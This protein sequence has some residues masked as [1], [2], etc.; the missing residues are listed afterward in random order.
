[1]LQDR[2]N[3]RKLR[4]ALEQHTNTASVKSE[5]HRKASLFFRI[6]P[7]DDERLFEKFVR[8]IRS[9]NNLSEARRMR[10]EISSQL[11]KDQRD[12]S[13]DPT[14]LKRLEAGKHLLDQQVSLL[15]SNTVDLKRNISL[16]DNGGRLNLKKK[17]G[18]L[19][20]IRDVTEIL[21]D[22]AG[23]SYFMEYMDRQHRLPL[24]QF[25]LVVDG[26]RN[27]LEDDEA[28]IVKWSSSDRNDLA[29]IYDVY[30]NA[31]ELKIAE[32]TKA[33]VREFL[34]AGSKASTVGYKRARAAVLKAQTEVQEE[35]QTRDLVGFKE[36]DLFYKFLGLDDPAKLMN[37]IEN[38]ESVDN[39]S[40]PYEHMSR[41]ASW[42]DSKPNA[43]PPNLH[44]RHS[45]DETKSILEYDPLGETDPLFE[46]AG[47]FDANE[48]VDSGVVEAMEAALN[49]IID[50]GKNAEFYNKT[51][52][53]MLSS[54]TP[55]AS[56]ASLDF[57]FAPRNAIV[58]DGRLTS[59]PIASASLENQK[60]PVPSIRDNRGVKEKEPVFH[61]KASHSSSDFAIKHEDSDA[62]ADFPGTATNSK[63]SLPLPPSISSLGLITDVKGGVF[64]D[65][66]FPDEAAEK[67]HGLD[68]DDSEF[69]T[70]DH[71]EEIHLAGPGDLGL[72]EAI[73][74]LSL[75][76][77]KLGTQEAVVDSLMKKAEL[78]NNAVE[79]RI[80][81]KS[82]ASLEREMRRKELQR[83]QYIVQESDN[84]LYGRASV[85]IRS[86]AIEN[87]NGREF[88]LC[89][90]YPRPLSLEPASV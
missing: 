33:D 40:D 82:K 23:L 34:D 15:A 17:I 36:S 54:K 79:L 19:R 70:D 74:N 31:S 71:E 80:L 68:E 9:C 13:S 3:V 28:A 32:R 25:W 75:E 57:S 5:R 22:S 69:P 73:S 72:A 66:L 4:E 10:S 45:F 64:S 47:E 26:M 21:R 43:H 1:M 86:F 30:L 60:R 35:M 76:I 2:N 58:V 61:A 84:T 53:G 8:A 42:A 85:N 37:G 46:P 20:E 63:K 38:M 16:P 51:E 27:P 83:Q 41:S 65:E 48:F 88:V 7:G 18:G 62:T 39:D 50:D 14:Y 6:K 49:N 52:N 24:V 29:Q 90:L 89:K 11:R 81:R 56:S 44:K 77:E 12:P 59:Q 67:F 87:E 78:T 55:M